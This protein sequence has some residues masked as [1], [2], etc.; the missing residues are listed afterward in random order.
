MG[1]VYVVTDSAA[2]VPEPLLRRYSIRIVPFQLIL[3]GR[4]YRDG[5]DITAAQFYE[6]L[7]RGGQMPRTSQPALG[8][9]LQVYQE[10]AAAGAQG[11]VSVHIPREL[12]GTVDTARLAA[13]MVS[14]V[15]I[16]VIDARTA[17]IAEGFVVLAAA[18]AA[19]AGA[20]L[21]EVARAAEQAVGRVGLLACVPLATVASL[22]R[23]GRCGD[24]E[25]LLQAPV[26][27]TPILRL[28]HGR[29]ALV[30][31]ARNRQRALNRLVTLMQEKAGRQPV[32]L[33]T[34]HA[35]DPEQAEAIHNRLCATLNVVES[36]ITEFT[37]V[38]GAHTGPGVIGVAFELLAPQPSTAGKAEATEE[39]ERCDRL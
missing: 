3:D 28:H 25:S 16:K 13:S 36:Y 32:R 15:P 24:A 27:I 8:D 1:K 14:Q 22:Q 34:F 35:D 26:N 38:M 31:V 7:E 23:T 2:C 30:G 21:E 39:A 4:Y 18:R 29:P 9:F 12:S 11:I 33:A 37:P 19:E 20:P 10:L 5:V 17:T 6:W